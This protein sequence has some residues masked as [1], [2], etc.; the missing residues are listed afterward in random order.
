MTRLALLM[1]FLQL[2]RTFLATCTV[3]CM[4]FFWN[5]ATTAVDGPVFEKMLPR[6][7]VVFLRV[8]PIETLLQHSTTKSILDTKEFKGLLRTPG[9]IKLR[10]GLTLFEFA[11]GDK[12]DSLA[13]KLTANGACVAIDKKTQGVVL[14]TNAES[15]EWLEEYLQRL[16]KLARTDAKNK[17]EPDPI[18]QADYRGLRG[19][20]YQNVVISNLGSVLIVTNK[21]ELAKDII[22]RTLD[23]TVDSLESN[24]RFQQATKSICDQPVNETSVH[25]ARGFLDLNELREAGVAKELLGEKTHDFAGELL[26]GGLLASL[27]KT[28]FASGCLMLEPSSI[29]VR[30]QVPYEIEWNKEFRTFFVGPDG[31]GFAPSIPV[32]GVLAS[33]SAYRDV[34]QMWRRAGDL[35][36]EKVNDQLAQADSTL[37]TLFSGKDFGSDIL[38]A[39]EPQIQIVASEQVYAPGVAPIIKLPSFGLVAK[40]KDVSMKKELKRTFQSF[41]GFL[42]VAGAMTGSPQLDLDTESIEGVQYYSATYLRETD[43]KYEGGLPIQFN[44]SPTLAFKNDIAIVASTLS[45]A[46]QM[47]IFPVAKAVEDANEGGVARVGETVSQ[48]NTVVHVNV[49]ALRSVLESNRQPL[50][51][52]NILE[53][54][55]SKSEAENEIGILMSVLSLLQSAKLSLRFDEFVRLELDIAFH[56]GRQ[57]L[58]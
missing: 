37:T 16:I 10:G 50:I 7:T 2:Q 20:E 25:F 1:S 45:F 8:D 21:S 40:L 54:G 51:A 26:L 17:G 9:A 49:D 3:S 29:S 44:F 28:S 23:A 39:I 13:N 56:P 14:L 42:N 58:K 52:Q 6:S 34:S 19:L 47:S 18:R 30:T 36:D 35:F 41:V 11:I 32:A 33:V 4:Y 53:K 48:D 55:H 43:R 57:T 31:K 27:Q 22:D 15:D 5:D 24:I 38:G 46:K 12:I